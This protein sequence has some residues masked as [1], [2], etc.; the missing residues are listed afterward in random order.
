MTKED[1]LELFPSGTFGYFSTVDANGYP[2]T[3][4]WQFQFEEDGRFYFATN[5]TK[6]V[7]TELCKNPK[8]AFTATDSK[9]IYTL[10]LTGLANVI[11]KPT[12]KEDAYYN[13]ADSVKSFYKE[14]SNPMLEIFYMSECSMRITKGFGLLED[15]D[16]GGK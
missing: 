12:E 9:G 2:Q 4:F 16:L 6:N 3:R 5:N 8:V 1:L 10:R 15:I 13:L 11:D 7:F 14:W